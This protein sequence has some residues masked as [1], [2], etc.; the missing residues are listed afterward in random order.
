[1]YESILIQDVLLGHMPWKNQPNGASY[2]IH[3]PTTK[4]PLKY[5]LLVLNHSFYKVWR[6][7]KR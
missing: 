5:K 7:I 4:E 2:T 3:N 1:M 6:L